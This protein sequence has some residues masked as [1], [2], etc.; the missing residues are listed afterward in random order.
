M[1]NDLEVNIAQNN[2]IKSENIFKLDFKG[3]SLKT[4]KKFVSWKEKMQIKYGKNAKLYYC[5]ED[6][7]YFYGTFSYEGSECPSCKNH[8]CYFCLRGTNICLD[9]CP[10][11]RAY[12]ILSYDALFFI[13]ENDKNYDYNYGD[14][15]SFCDVFYKFLLPLYTSIYLEG[16]ISANFYHKLFYPEEKDKDRYYYFLE[17]SIATWINIII[18]ILI[19]LILSLIFGIHV[20][21]FK[22]LLLVFSIFPKH[23]PIKYYLGIL[24]MGMEQFR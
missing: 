9:C 6:N 1:E 18:N 20:I 23:Y 14:H 2:E 3:Q 8:I 19:A 17:D 4:N 10:L 21:Y 22:V 7:L 13:K 24:K 16:I 11:G 5:K 12:R 15:Y